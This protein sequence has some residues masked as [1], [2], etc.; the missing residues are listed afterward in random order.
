MVVLYNVEIILTTSIYF[1]E[2][3]TDKLRSLDVHAKREFLKQFF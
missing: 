3:K 2:T 1:D